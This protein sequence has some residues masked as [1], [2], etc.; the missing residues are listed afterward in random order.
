MLTVALIGPDGAG[1]TTV[2]LRLQD[3]LAW[4]VKYVYMG[5]NAESS[6]HM[7]PTTRMIRAVKRRCGARPDTAGPRPHE[8]VAR[9]PKGFVRRLMTDVKAMLGLLNRMGEEW[10]RQILIGY[11]RCRRC[12]VVLDRHYFADYYAYDIA[13]TD[14]RRP[15]HR[16]IHG[17]MLQHLYPKPN[18]VIYLDAP[19]EVLLARKGE[20]TLE[21]LQRRRED[22]MQLRGRVPNFVVVDAN[23]PAES[24]ADEVAEHIRRFRTLR[25]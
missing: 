7:L 5:V 19:A 1:K 20:G 21:L 14:H 8:E 18:L 13:K 10:F 3:L 9:R 2:G 24:V 25:R 16:R 12:V 11:Y 15:L 4:P 23:R 6:N 22:Y 17:F